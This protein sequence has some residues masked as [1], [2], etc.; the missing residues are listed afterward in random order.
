MR[1]AALV[2]ALRLMLVVELRRCEELLVLSLPLHCRPLPR[3]VC[4]WVVPLRDERVTSAVE[5]QQGRHSG[6]SCGL[7]LQAGSQRATRLLPLSVRASA[8]ASVRCRRSAVLLSCHCSQ[9]SSSRQRT[10]DDRHTHDT[11]EHRAA[12]KNER[13]IERARQKQTKESLVEMAAFQQRV[14]TSIVCVQI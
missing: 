11:T 5:G 13:W 6:L 2:D 7:A 12:A 4:E 8:V 9:P 10:R 3:R 1:L 14:G